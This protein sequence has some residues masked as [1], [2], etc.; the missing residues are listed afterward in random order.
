MEQVLVLFHPLSQSDLAQCQENA[1]QQ[2]LEFKEM[3][4]QVEEDEEKIINK[5]Q[6]EYE[7]KLHSEKE[8]NMNLKG[9]AGVMS[10]KVGETFHVVSYVLSGP[11]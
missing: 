5:I 8:S 2:I 7:K 4:K 1:Q 10:Q 11:E 6:I 9:E 3:M